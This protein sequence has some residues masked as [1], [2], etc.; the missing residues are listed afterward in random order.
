METASAQ[1][2]GFALVYLPGTSAISV[3]GAMAGYVGYGDCL[4]MEMHQRV[5]PINLR[6]HSKTDM[7]S[8]FTLIDRLM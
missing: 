7:S 8:K 4:V 2:A 1:A 3:K 5:R 6:N